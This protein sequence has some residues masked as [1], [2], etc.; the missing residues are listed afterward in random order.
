MR[1]TFSLFLLCLSFVTFAYSCPVPQ[2]AFAA[3]QRIS[4]HS[5]FTVPAK[6]ANDQ[7]ENLA[8][9]RIVDKQPDKVYSALQTQIKT[10]FQGSL[11]FPWPLP[12]FSFLWKQQR[13]S[14][15]K[16]VYDRGQ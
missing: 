14:Q 12:D 3:S 7:R 16:D 11:T 9:I 8:R 1:R 5:V 10:R 6:K 2:H 4:R 15:K 13:S